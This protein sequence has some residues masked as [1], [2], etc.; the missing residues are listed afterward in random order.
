MKFYR[1]AI[2][3]EGAEVIGYDNIKCNLAESSV[4]DRT[5]D[6]LGIE[7]KGLALPY[8]QDHCGMTELR[9]LI[10]H[11]ASS[12]AATEHVMVTAG[13]S[14]ALFIVAITLLDKGDHVV[15][16][17]PNY[18]TNLETPEA[19][20]S[21]ISYVDLKYE[22]GFRLDL[23][24]LESI[25][26]ERTKYVSLT[27]PNNPDGGMLSLAELKS[28]ID[29]V[30]RNNSYL[31]VD[32]TYR[33]MAHVGVLPVAA[34]LSDR[35]ISVSSL[36]KSYGVPG[37]RI[38]WIHCQDSQLMESFLCA[39]EQISIHGSILDE[40]VAYETLVHKDAWL[41]Q[42]RPEILAGKQCVKQWV[43]GEPYID[44]VEPDGGTTCFTKIDE[45][46]DI[47]Y[48]SFYQ[49]LLS[50]YG[51]YVGPGHWFGFPKNY[52][53]IGFAWN[54]GQ[55]LRNGLEGISSNIRDFVLT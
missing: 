51:T 7:L 26:E 9:Q 17:R 48:D 36:S 3:A 27:C 37:I 53:R 49:L 28:V 41:K 19:I 31:L 52:M 23:D 38:G 34:T 32:E 47:D 39:K 21:E 24:Y 1:S 30:E 50:K 40:T 55:T 45:N 5:M 18:C 46:L 10:A 12:Q 44:W 33:E 2:E 14:A 8:A 54:D 6:D 43:E 29:I 4:R 11:Q 25:V 20:G 15:I 16:S 42:V 13:A 35:V 22:K